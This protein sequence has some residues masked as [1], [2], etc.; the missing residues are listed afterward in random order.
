MHPSTCHLY[1]SNA[2]LEPPWL[3][4]A[5]RKVPCQARAAD[6]MESAQL[7]GRGSL[8]K[9]LQGKAKQADAL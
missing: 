1:R 3:R 5:L 4:L 7:Q 2:W 8:C 6:R 9:L